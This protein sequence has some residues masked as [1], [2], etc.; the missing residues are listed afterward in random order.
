MTCIDQENA[1]CKIGDK[2]TEGVGDKKIT[3]RL[4]SK[5]NKGIN[6]EISFYGN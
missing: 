3:F 6:A 1:A 5:R 2:E 4:E